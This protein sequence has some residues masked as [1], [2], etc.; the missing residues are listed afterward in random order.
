M[1]LITLLPALEAWEPR[2]LGAWEA[3]R[4]QGAYPGLGAGFLEL[5]GREPGRPG[6]SE[7]GSLGGRSGSLGGLEAPGS[8]VP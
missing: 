2:G 3:S 6:T 1:F 7:V 8:P 5:G 4:P